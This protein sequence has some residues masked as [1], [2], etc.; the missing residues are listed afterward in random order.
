MLSQL[1][2]QARQQWMGVTLGMLALFIALGGAVVFAHGGDASLVHGCVKPVAPTGPQPN[3]IIVEPNEA[4]PAGYGPVDWAQQGPAGP[5]GE[6]GPQ[7]PPPASL[8]PEP[9][10][11]VQLAQQAGVQLGNKTK[12]VEKSTDKGALPFVR[13][14]TSPH[15]PASHPKRVTGGYK[16]ADVAPNAA[17]DV[18]FNGP[19]PESLFQW[20]VY[21]TSSDTS[22]TL[23]A[24]QVC[25]K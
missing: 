25:K 16:T 1:G 15:C 12:I 17:F 19:R 4:C 23:T 8:S 21:A 7:G 24:Y 2:R 10:T 6:V 9:V 11:F 3:V 20:S 14:V 22:W 18:N 5:Q 13:T